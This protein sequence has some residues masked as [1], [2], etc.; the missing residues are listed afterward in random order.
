MQ[1]VETLSSKKIVILGT[2]GTI[3]GQSALRDDNI[4]YLAAQ[5][6]ISTLT[7]SVP[8]LAAHVAGF[9]LVTEQV[10]QVDSKDMDEKVWCRLAQRTANALA[11]PDVHAVVIT[12]GTDTIEET[13]F[14]LQSVLPANKP[15]VLTCAM[16]PSTALNPDGP[17]NLR[18]ALSVAMDPHAEGVVVVCAGLVHTAQHVQKIHPYRLDA[19]SS[20]DAGPVGSVENA[21]V[22]WTVLPLPC[23][24]PAW[25]ASGLSVDQPWPQVEIVL[26]H[27]GA[28]GAVVQ[29][30][31]H[32]G[33][34]GLVV[35]GTGNGTLSQ[36]LTRA[37]QLAMASGV[38][39]LRSTRC[40]FGQV[41]AESDA[42]IP[43]AQGLSPVKA[44]VAL[45]LS[46]LGLA[47]A[48]ASNPKN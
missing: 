46:L 19:F 33:V 8:G 42:L 43:V 10:A 35:A 34:Q 38:Q 2:G 45:Q 31:M 48:K 37:L 3:A 25:Q 27:A 9:A 26:N 7:A 28:T 12:H 24:P 4:N 1:V 36:P 16:R 5:V 20:G 40:A 47:A 23:K 22:R 30:L 41:M 6:D 32:A 18:D 15:V 39:V 14:F 13:A 44:R 11:Q 29:A 21:R 17:Q